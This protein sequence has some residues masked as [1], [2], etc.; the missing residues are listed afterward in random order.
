MTPPEPVK[1]ITLGGLRAQLAKLEDMP[2]TT[3]VILAANPEGLHYSPAGTLV[4]AW[5]VGDASSG[6]VYL[7][8]D[9]RQYMEDP[10]EFPPVPPGSEPVPAVCLYPQG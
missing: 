5:Y 10:G 1:G 6:D 8:D 7:T 4:E 9:V 2:D 3:L